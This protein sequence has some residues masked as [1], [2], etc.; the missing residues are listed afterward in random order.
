LVDSNRFC[1]CI[2][3]HLLSPLHSVYIDESSK[4]RFSLQG[5]S[6]RIDLQSKSAGMTLKRTKRGLTLMQLYRATQ[7]AR[8]PKGVEGRTTL[9]VL[10]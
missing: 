9:Y 6:P 1:K 8:R 5:L 2:V 7:Y 10:L 4:S 3:M